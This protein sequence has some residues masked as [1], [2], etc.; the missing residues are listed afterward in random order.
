MPKKKKKSVIFVITIILFG[1]YL[2]L[3]YSFT[4]GY[5]DYKEYNKMQL[6]EE[7]MKR[8]EKDV[9]EGKNVLLEDYITEEKDYSSAASKVGVL[10]G[11][12]TEKIIIKGL[13]GIFH[14][15]GSFV[16]N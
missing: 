16:S 9:S 2:A 12:Y 1:I 15:I 10:A 3:Y 6:T 8:F 4:F 11:E 7:A 13:G 14:I 5:Y